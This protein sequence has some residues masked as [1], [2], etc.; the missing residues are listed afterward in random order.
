MKKRANPKPKI[1]DLCEI[2]G[3]SYAMTHEIIPGNAILLLDDYTGSGATIK[4]AAR[5]LRKEVKKKQEIERIA[6]SAR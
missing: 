6:L 5:V 1:D 3:T 2:C 4:E